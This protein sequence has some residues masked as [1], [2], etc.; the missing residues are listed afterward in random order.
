MKKGYHELAY[1]QPKF[2]CNQVLSICK[3]DGT[4]PIMT[5]DL[6]REALKNLYVKIELDEQEESAAAE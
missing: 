1:Y 4:K 5:E 3:Y 6:V 2:I